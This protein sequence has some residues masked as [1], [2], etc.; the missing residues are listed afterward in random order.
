V[1]AAPETLRAEVETAI[2][3]R[4]LTTVERLGRDA[5][6]WLAAPPLWSVEAAQAAGFPVESVRTF[7]QAA[8]DAGWCKVRGSLLDYA[9]ADL[10]FWMPDEVRREV[11][12]LLRD[13][14]TASSVSSASGP[15]P[16]VQ[17]VLRVAERVRGVLSADEV[18]GGPETEI[19]G[20][21][22]AWTNLMSGHRADVQ[23][24]V[25]RAL[26]EYARLTVADRALG[27]AQDIVAAGEA[28]APVLAGAAEQA[29]SRARRLLALGLRRR[30]DERALGRYLDRPELSDAVARLLSR[31]AA[32]DS[33]PAAGEAPSAAPGPTEPPWA[34]HLR[35]AGGVGKTMMIR[36]LASGLY[37]AQRGQPPI[38]VARVDFDHLSPDYP[39]RR[40]VQLLLELADELALHTAA[41]DRAD[42]ALWN[43]R[44]RAARAHEAVS[45]LRE[46]GTRPLGHD[47]VA[48]AVD[49]FGDVL[50]ELGDVLLILDTCEELAKAD[51][52]EQAAPAVRAAL[53]IVERLHQRAPSVRVLFAGRRPLPPQSYLVVQPVAGFTVDEARQYLAA[54][55]GRPLPPDLALEMIRQSPAVDGPVPAAGTLPD[56]VSPFDLALY[57]AWADEDPNLDAAQV[58]AG[59]NA[60]IEGRI[61]E[62]LDDPL[63]VRALPVLASAGRCR[64]AAVAEL[65]GADPAAL[66]RRLAEQEWIDAD[67]DPPTHVAARP[68]L[69]R[70]LRRYFESDQRRI[71]F[72]AANAALASALV[73]RV[74]AVPLAEIDVDELI[75]ALRLAT[76]AEAAGLWD[77]IAERATEP[78]G[79]W[80]TVLNMTRRILGEWDEEEW[81]TTPA[82]RAGVVAAHIAASRRDSPAFDA[83]GPWDTVRGWAGQHPDP[84]SQQRL[85]IRG[86]LGGLSYTPDDDSLRETVNRGIARYQQSGIPDELAAAAVDAW[87][88]LLETGHISLGSRLPDELG[89]IATSGDQR[90]GLW[91]QVCL[92]RSFADAHPEAARNLLA[93]AEIAAASDGPEF[94]WPDWIPP[95]D[96]LARVRI[97]R[98]LITPPDDLS[99]LDDW[100]S[101]ATARLD[102]IDGERL[103]SL[104]LR[105]RLRHGVIDAAVAQRWESADGYYPDRV[106]TGSAHDLVPPLFVSVA[107]AWISAGR[108]ERALAL[109][110]RRRSEAVRTR[111]DDT[112]VRQAEAAIVAIISRL[113]LTDRHA[114]LRRLASLSSP[115]DPE[116][117][118]Q[119]MRALATIGLPAL[120]M[121]MH[122][123]YLVKPESWHA[124]WQS[125]RSADIT[126][127]LALTPQVAQW[128]PPRTSADAADI[129]ADLEELMALFPEPKGSATAWANALAAWLAQPAPPPSARSP[130]P[131]REVRAVLRRKALAAETFTPAVPVPHRLLAEIAFEEGRLMALRFPDA[132]VRLLRISATAYAAAGDLLGLLLA[133]LAI[134]GTTL[135]GARADISRRAAETALGRLGQVN[136]ALHA[137]LTGPPDEAGPWRYWA[138]A[139]R[140]M[141][142]P[143]PERVPDDVTAIVHVVDAG[144]VPVPDSDDVMPSSETGPP[145][146]PV[147][148]LSDDTTPAQQTVSA[149]AGSPPPP[150]TK[151]LTFTEDSEHRTRGT[152][153]RRRRRLLLRTSRAT[154]AIAVGTICAGVLVVIHTQ[155]GPQAHNAQAGPT[156]TAGGAPTSTGSTGGTPTSTVTQTPTGAPTSVGPT[157]TAGSSATPATGSASG[158]SAELWFTLLAAFI[159]V[160]AALAALLVWYVPRIRQLARQRG[161]GASPLGTLQFDV[162]LDQRATTREVRLMVSLRP[163]RTAPPQAR[164]A[165]ALRFPAF[166]VAT[167]RPVGS[168]EAGYQGVAPLADSP[169]ESPPVDWTDPH[170]AASAA[171]W[172]RGRR[173]AAGIIRVGS[174][175][176]PVPPS[177]LLERRLVASLSPAAAGRIAWI[178][179]VGAPGDEVFATGSTTSELLA[180][181]AWVRAIGQYYTQPAGPQPP[182]GLVH[183]IGRAVATS[184]GPVMDVTGETTKATSSRKLLDATALGATGAAIVILQAEPVPGDT[185]AGDPPDDQA[186]KLLLAAYMAADG[187]GAVLLLPVLPAGTTAEVA[188]ILTAYIEYPPAD[189]PQVLLTRLRSEIAPHVPPSVL[190]DVVLFLNAANHRS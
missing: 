169:T 41:S 119:A 138:T 158:A 108:P 130:E 51:L 121:T 146:V 149:A 86:A 96:L 52:G 168:R 57:A 175:Y 58:S 65:I 71:A 123:R 25:P 81:P 22:R 62:R 157:R 172:R 134:V 145:P 21:L 136:P 87:H 9:P 40:P 189:G 182:A 53:D 180:P 17:D 170:P 10:I 179:L 63:V 91:A 133:H 185:I 36:Y 176:I 82:L 43:F 154:V 106:P 49:A 116:T 126:L 78:P 177:D 88:R 148:A 59:S 61:I 129:R 77:S 2:R 46:A 150:G 30:Q 39:V 38:R 73:T 135:S 64:V 66:G 131:H 181:R 1:T 67:G 14:A 15:G 166:W 101:H 98:G 99:L 72:A 140:D 11:M 188:R 6:V 132:A 84:D 3:D 147:P 187:V 20:A 69:A 29:L 137:L 178:R 48:R 90:V 35:G 174:D 156:V 118:Y 183:V 76:P 110:D 7:V 104:C 37:A 32:T 151:T 23:D 44:A 111:Q 163:W 42:R 141:D 160:L 113:G 165:L 105:I 8:C 55:T 56:R 24:E 173:T 161:I 16:L 155:L 142:A 144:H 171:W 127:L 114:F 103:A 190:D 112:T 19:P 128:P 95:G 120:T 26:V 13:Q 70:R 80:G 60:Y 92:A 143:R 184:T 28:I 167:R 85:L 45:G 139:V 159:A 125:Q 100:E 102:T 107:Q 122:E 54:S 33:Q 12:D 83:Q 5:V 75:A 124:R 164:L 4:R 47:E 79:R 162:T 115:A 94:S 93:A 68:A 74:G 97:E 109:L 50:A 18:L 186:E 89:L 117:T 152:P 31:D 34:L 153:A 27:A